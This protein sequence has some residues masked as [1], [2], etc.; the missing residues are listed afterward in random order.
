MK[1]YK[2]SKREN[3]FYHQIV[4]VSKLA[5]LELLLPVLIRTGLL[6]LLGENESIDSYGK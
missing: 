2:V 6:F 4:S 1:G 3:Y 5:V